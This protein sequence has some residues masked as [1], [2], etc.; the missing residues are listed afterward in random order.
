MDDIELRTCRRCRPGPVPGRSGEPPGDTRRRIYNF[1]WPSPKPH[2][3][4]SV[5]HDPL[6][7]RRPLSTVYCPLCAVHPMLSTVCCPLPTIRCP[8]SAV[9]RP[10][11]TAQHKAQ[12]ASPKAKSPKNSPHIKPKKGRKKQCYPLNSAFTYARKRL[13]K[14]KK[15]SECPEAIPCQL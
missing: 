15:K 6:V 7:V 13:G 4:P 5:K 10:L 9:R 12:Q 3:P 14:K 1:R 2:A 11:S 8:P